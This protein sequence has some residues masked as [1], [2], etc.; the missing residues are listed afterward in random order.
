MQVG[1]AED[2]EL[3][4]SN[5]RSNANVGTAAHDEEQGSNGEWQCVG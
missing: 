1:V 2:G 4:D 5:K 3:V